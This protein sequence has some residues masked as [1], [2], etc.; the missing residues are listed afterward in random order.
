MLSPSN[1]IVYDEYYSPPSDYNEDEEKERLEMEAKHREFR[2]F[3]FGAAVCQDKFWLIDY[4][5]AR[6]NHSPG[7]Y[8]KTYVIYHCSDSQVLKFLDRFPSFKDE[9]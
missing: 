2:D 6:W 7:V 3:V 4:L 5:E 8:T 1:F 9:I